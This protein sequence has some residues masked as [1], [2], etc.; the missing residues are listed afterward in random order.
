MFGEDRLTDKSS[1]NDELLDDSAF[2]FSLGA[3]SGARLLFS[4][5]TLKSSGLAS[6]ASMDRTG[7]GSGSAGSVGGSSLT[8]Q[9]G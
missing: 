3:S 7:L 4:A 6:L 2:T 1:G 8:A 5:L 9:R